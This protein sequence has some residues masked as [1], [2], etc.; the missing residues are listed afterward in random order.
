MPDKKVQGEFDNFVISLGKEIRLRKHKSKIASG[1]FCFFSYCESRKPIADLVVEFDGL[2]RIMSSKYRDL[3]GRTNREKGM[4]FFKLLIEDFK[5]YQK[6][7]PQEK[8]KSKTIKR[9]I[10]EN[11][12]NIKHYIE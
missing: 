7:R 8:N 1:G 11:L 5:V 2:M 12:I 4:R 3:Q 9:I 6:I 10:D